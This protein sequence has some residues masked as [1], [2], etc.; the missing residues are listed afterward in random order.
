MRRALSG[1]S[2]APRELRRPST[3]LDNIALVPA[4]EL[5]SLATWQQRAMRLPAGSTL[6]IVQPDN[7]RLQQVSQKIHAA[8]Q[9]QG[10]RSCIA[11]CSRSAGNAHQRE[12]AVSSVPHVA[13]HSQ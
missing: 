3:Q 11:I 2:R 1:W 12:R 5:A 4:S 8:L 9:A 6:L 7:P 13:H 10:R